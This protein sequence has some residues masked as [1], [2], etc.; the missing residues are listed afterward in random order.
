MAD[1]RPRD[2][3]DAGI[4]QQHIEWLLAQLKIIQESL[5]KNTSVSG[6]MLNLYNQ[7][8]K[9][10][11]YP[12]FTPERN[13]F[14]LLSNIATIWN[15]ARDECKE[16]STHM[17]EVM[18]LLEAN[19]EM[20]S[21]EEKNA[22]KPQ[23]LAEFERS[24]QANREKVAYLVNQ[25]NAAFSQFLESKRGL[26]YVAPQVNLQ[27]MLGD[28]LKQAAELVA[29]K[30]IHDKNEKSFQA[31][32]PLPTWESLHGQ[33]LDDPAQARQAFQ[34][35]AK[36]VAEFH[37]RNTENPIAAVLAK[38]ASTLIA[39][40]S[41]S[42]KERFFQ[43]FA[44]VNRAAS[45]LQGTSPAD[46][47]R[48]ILKSTKE[49]IQATVTANEWDEKAVV[50]R[51]RSKGAGSIVAPGAVAGA[52]SGSAT[53]TTPQ[54]ADTMVV[55]NMDDA[56]WDEINRRM[57]AGV[58]AGRKSTT[59][60]SLLKD[61]KTAHEHKDKDV[62][63]TRARG[64]E[65]TGDALPRPAASTSNPIIPAS[66]RRTSVT[67]PPQKNAGA[68]G[69]EAKSQL[70]P[71]APRKKYEPILPDIDENKEHDFAAHERRKPPKKG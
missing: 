48:K 30:G 7:L 6:K 59:H 57:E 56:E 15:A 68:L 71:K 22:S 25:D 41:I 18:K 20:K 51:T 54:Q 21:A 26:P 40:A 12:G 50:T 31:L 16:I 53:A 32:Y 19:R 13:F 4:S 66:I 8:S 65:L 49:Q 45:R 44:E 1:P 29:R 14:K 39:D 67:T 38:H 24:T 34:E 55:E 2:E 27:I 63:Q 64:R 61:L 5:P 70:F 69:G 9:E 33:R 11:D 10:K 17:P 23:V 62:P 28:L 60:G 43:L 3:K 46:G 35:L 58:A 37:S 47:L 36:Q 52:G 42:D